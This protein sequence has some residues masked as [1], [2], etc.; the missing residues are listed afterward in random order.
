[1]RSLAIIFSAVMLAVVASSGSA[2]C[3]EEESVDAAAGQLLNHVLN[4]GLGAYWQHLLGLTLGQRQQP[5]PPACHGN[6]G[7]VNR[8]VSGYLVC[9][10]NTGF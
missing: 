7:N 9:N 6:D 5:G 10:R 8:H 2:G 1:M 3:D 4:H